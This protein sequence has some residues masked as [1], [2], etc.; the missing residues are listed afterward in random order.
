M[1][2]GSSFP[3]RP[4]IT[5]ARLAASRCRHVA[6]VQ[7]GGAVAA[8]GA[9]AG[10]TDA[11]SSRPQRR[12]RPGTSPT[13]SWHKTLH[14]SQCGRNAFLELTFGAWSR[15]ASDQPD[16]DQH[17]TIL[18]MRRAEHTVPL[19]VVSPRGG[20]CPLAGQPASRNTKCPLTKKAYKA[21]CGRQT[22]R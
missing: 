4:C 5:G 1:F 16:E 20:Q 6:G 7:D 3:D 12:Y 19:T 14:R 11:A 8:A 9:A 21:C 2:Q 17:D 13:V 15:A 10:R 22:L 18:V